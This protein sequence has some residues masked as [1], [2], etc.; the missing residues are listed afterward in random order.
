MTISSWITHAAIHAGSSIT[1]AISRPVEQ[2]VNML[3]GNDTPP[4]EALFH[5]GIT[6]MIDER[7]M[8][9]ALLRHGVSVTVAGDP[10]PGTALG[11]QQWIQEL[12]NQH[13][14]AQQHLPSPTES[15]LL[16]NRGLFSISN[17]DRMLERQGYSDPRI[18]E[19]ISNLRYEVPGSSD[20]V[21]FS[22]RHVFEPDLISRLG[23]DD[24]FNRTLDF[25]HKLQGLN[26]PIFS[27]PFAKQYEEF[28]ASVPGGKAVDA[29]S[30][31]GYELQEPTWAQAFWW[32]HWVLPSPS[33]AYEMYFR[34]RPERN[35]SLDPPFARE[36]EFGLDDLNLLLRAN[37][38][39]PKLRPLLA[40]IAHRIPGIRFLRQL[41][42]TEVFDQ[43]AVKELLLRQ[44]YS[45]GD[46]SVLA[47]S[48]ERNDR[49][50]RRKGIEQQ[51][52]GQIA[53]YW[54]L[55]IIDRGQFKA[56]LIEHGLTPGQA[57]ETVSLA[58]LDLK[59]KRI[60]K[61]IDFVRRQMIRGVINA[62][63][64]ADQLRQAGLVQDRIALYIDDWNREVQGQHKTVSAQKAVQWACKGLINLQELQARLTNLGYHPQDIAGLIAE[65]RVCQATLATRAAAA[66][67]KQ[68]AASQRQ[69]VQQQK[70][71]A[72][73]IVAAR[74]Q[75]AAHGSPSQLRKW[76]CHGHIGQPE[77]YSRLRFLGWP[78]EDILRLISDC[79]TSTGGGKGGQRGG[80]VLGG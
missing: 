20:L 23:Y 10:Q 71:A 13:Y 6:G 34:L 59:F 36:L 39:P 72:Q 7:S 3:A 49:D 12:W 64:A 62:A 9:E 31:A 61:I 66:Q 77:V 44:G 17:L 1:G 60:T 43:K 76:F 78:D 11:A 79:K 21:R 16:T 2:S 27:G 8:Q 69:L 30:Y 54:E 75:L 33:Q 22:V 25:F 46:A 50:Q 73:A 40:A 53:K 41:R 65:A 29:G 42:A 56:L 48:V 4:P 24:E 26:Y 68:V 51:A 47:E 28:V 70:A 32:S 80:S 67:E 35:R 14:F 52:R 37:D 18:R 38:Y 58:D 74:R 63:Q 45:D 15:L 19:A 57:D 5:L 55:G